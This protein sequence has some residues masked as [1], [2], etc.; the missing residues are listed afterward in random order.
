MAIL[1]L[2]QNLH[3]LRTEMIC[4]LLFTNIE[5]NC[6]FVVV[7]VTSDIMTS[8]QKTQWVEYSCV[9]A[10]NKDMVRWSI[11]NKNGMDFFTVSFLIQSNVHS[12]AR[13]LYGRYYS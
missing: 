9:F 12:E 13:L 1:I 11:H 8:I 5:I 2:S 3:V 7:H 10:A 4:T 6:F